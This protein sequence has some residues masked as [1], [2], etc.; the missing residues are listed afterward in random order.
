[1]VRFFF[2]QP[3]PAI[4]WRPW[5]MGLVVGLITGALDIIIAMII[6]NNMELQTVVTITL[7]AL[8]IW[9]VAGMAWHLRRNARLTQQNEQ[10]KDLAWRWVCGFV[11]GLL[12]GISV[13]TTM[14]IYGLVYLEIPI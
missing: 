3:A 5:T 8:A 14:I 10:N 12:I 2:L 1:M 11:I 7:W 13:V 6:S 4:Y 9:F